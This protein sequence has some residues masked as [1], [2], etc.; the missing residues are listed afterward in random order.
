M[1]FCIEKFLLMVRE[2]PS[3]KVN[4]TVD[5]H[6]PV[7]IVGMN[8]RS[9]TML[10]GFFGFLGKLSSTNESAQK[11]STSFADQ[12]RM[13]HETLSETN[14]SKRSFSGEM[15]GLK[16]YISAVT[17]RIDMNYAQNKTQLGV[18]QVTEPSIHTQMVLGGE[19]EPLLAQFSF[20]SL[21]ISDTTPFY[22][23]LYSERLAV[24]LS[25]CEERCETRRS[26]STDNSASQPKV[27]VEIT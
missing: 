24:Q 17:L 7:V 14:I 21:T 6:L 26:T 9:W 27:T 12:D 8:R 11:L 1:L 13:A 20:C 25:D 16:L 23:A 3:R 15:Y 2:L 10:L 5:A 18:L 4:C 19:E 22:S